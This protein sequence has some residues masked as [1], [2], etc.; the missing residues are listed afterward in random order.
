MATI[1][2]LIKKIDNISLRE[3]IQ[4]EINH[5]NKGRRFGLVFEQHLPEATPIY[6]TPI[7]KGSTVSFKGKQIEEISR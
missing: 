6:N 7:K 5:L 1:D 3:R 2:E 4:E